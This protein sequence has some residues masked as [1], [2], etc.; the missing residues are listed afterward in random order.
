MRFETLLFDLDG[1]LAD[2]A[3]DIA[4]SMNAALG[5]LGLPSLASERIVGHVGGGVRRLVERCFADMPEPHASRGRGQF[6][7]LY[8]AFM[9]TYDA[10][11][12]DR[13]RL[14]PGVA[15]TLGRFNGSKMAVVSNKPEAMSRRVVEGLGVG[16][17][18]SIVVGGDTYPTRKPDPRPVLEVMAKLPGRALLIGD[19]AVDIAA[20]AAAGI[21]VAVV[22]YGYGRGDD[23]SPATYTLSRFEELA[24][25]VDGPG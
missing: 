7:A 12:L 8:S 14:Y 18:F 10:H 22:T 6:D 5:R 2:T 1:T 15:E 17:H 13:T 9:E 11:L 23:L 24:A 25:V 20:G 19:S 21:P 4:A 16:R 3:E